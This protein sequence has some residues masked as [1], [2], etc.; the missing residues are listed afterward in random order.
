MYE[1][2]SEDMP[3]NDASLNLFTKRSRTLENIPPTQVR[4]LFSKTAKKICCVLRKGFYLLFCLIR[5]VLFFKVLSIGTAPKELP[6]AHAPSQLSAKW[7][8]PFG[9]GRQFLIKN[10]PA[11]RAQLLTFYPLLSP[12]L[13]STFSCLGC[14]LSTCVTFGIP[15]KSLGQTRSNPIQ[16]ITKRL[17]LATRERTPFN[18]DMETLPDISHACTELAKCKCKAGRS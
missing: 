8:C 18:A 11:P 6:V 17:W 3:V 12:V 15:S 10:L 7:K 2:G 14:S 1:R 13:S 4:N 16:T 9:I 5:L